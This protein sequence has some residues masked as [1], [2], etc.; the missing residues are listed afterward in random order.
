MTAVSDA[1]VR[2]ATFAFCG[3]PPQVIGGTPYMMDRSANGLH[4]EL[5][6]MAAP[7]YGFSRDAKGAGQFAFSGAGQYGKLSLQAYTSMPTGECTFVV[8]A[9]GGYVLFSSYDAAGPPYT[10]HLLSN[11]T[12]GGL[13]SLW[14]YQMQNTGTTPYFTTTPGRP[15]SSPYIE[16]IELRTAPQAW[17]SGAPITATWITGAF[18][19]CVF[20]PLVRPTVWAG[21]NGLNTSAGTL[22][23]L[24]LWPWALSR[25]DAV[26]ITRMILDGV[27]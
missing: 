10:G 23:H 14:M 5:I 8:S 1:M 25:S 4:A 2:R 18:G 21:T 13:S 6:G 12:G 24:S 7:N 15:A 22:R 19:T 16:V 20:N 3:D 27:L 11:P 17:R 9:V 26:D